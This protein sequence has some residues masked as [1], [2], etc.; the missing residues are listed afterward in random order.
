[1]ASPS[2]LTAKQYKTNTHNCCSYICVKLYN[3]K[4]F[5]LLNVNHEE[6]DDS[7]IFKQ[8]IKTTNIYMDKQI[9]YWTSHAWAQSDFP[10]P[11]MQIF[12]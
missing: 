2:S 4:H 7:S 11:K 5:K 1:M 3:M 8:V 9:N 12:F 6:L 10:K